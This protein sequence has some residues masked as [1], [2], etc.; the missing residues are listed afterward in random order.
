[1]AADWPDADDPLGMLLLRHDEHPRNTTCGAVR[2]GDRTQDAARI[3]DVR[4]RRRGGPTL[5][6]PD[7]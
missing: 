7:E 6:F 3:P 5:E 1:M 4:A 2:R